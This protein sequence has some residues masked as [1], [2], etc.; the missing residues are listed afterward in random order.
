[1]SFNRLADDD[2]QYKRE[3]R[4]NVSILSYI[5]DPHRY[6]HKS[7]C[8]HELGLIAGSAVSHV[9]ANLIDV[10]SELRGQT[11]YLSKC[12][13]NMYKPPAPGQ[14][15]RNDK[16]APISTEPKHLKSCQM[17]GYKSVPLPP[18]ME[19]PRCA[20]QWPTL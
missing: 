1:M 19:V 3:L 5:V 2:C 20:F 17:I 11:R 12:G 18:P 14:P 9:N 16:T 7:K 8:R 6:E 10:D 4:E 13:G 15:I